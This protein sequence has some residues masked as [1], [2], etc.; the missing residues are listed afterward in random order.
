MRIRKYY[1][2]KKMIGYAL[3]MKGKTDREDRFLTPPTG[4]EAKAPKAETLA[5]QAKRLGIKYTKKG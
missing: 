4:K 2:T 3:T 1:F 5:E